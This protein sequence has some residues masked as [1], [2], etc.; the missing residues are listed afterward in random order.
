MS[1][2]A[3]LKE[4]QLSLLLMVHHRSQVVPQTMML[5]K[6]DIAILRIHA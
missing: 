5:S 4:M 3:K 1:T 2:L 6:R